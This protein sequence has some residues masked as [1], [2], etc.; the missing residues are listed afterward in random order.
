MNS[1]LK[2]YIHLFLHWNVW[3]FRIFVVIKISAT[4]NLGIS[5]KGRERALNHVAVQLE[6][7]LLWHVV[8]E[9]PNSNS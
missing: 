5:F 7:W 3:N 4:G 8:S 2:V 9:V 1:T 6:M